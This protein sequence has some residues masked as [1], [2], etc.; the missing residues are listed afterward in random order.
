MPSEFTNSPKLIKGALAVYESQARGTQPKIIVFQ[1][2]PEQMRRSF[3]LRAA[4]REAQNVGAA[5]EDVQRTQGPP[6]ETINLSV[7]LNAADQL[8]EPDK[9]QV[10]V[11]NGLHPELASLELL[12]Y[13]STARLQQDQSR[14]RQG[15]VQITPPDVP[16]VLLVWGQA[17]VIP[18]RLTTLSI[19]EEA[20][21]QNLNPIQARIEL[22]MQVLTNAELP[23]DGIGND[24]FLSYQRQKEQLAQQRQPRG[25]EDRVKGLLPT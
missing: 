3:A 21:D 19:T 17:R 18:V 16:V 2:N 22:A 24:A 1:Y 5:R 15:T 20:F 25:S 23:G 7:F 13:Q 10:V 14:A 11:Q 6:V 8:A 9:N 4:P 12:F